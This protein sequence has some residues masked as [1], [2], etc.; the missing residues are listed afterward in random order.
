MWITDLAFSNLLLLFAIMAKAQYVLTSTED[1][2]EKFR[3]L[4]SIKI[5]ILTG[6]FIAVLLGIQRYWFAPFG[7]APFSGASLIMYLIILHEFFG[8]FAA[9]FMKDRFIHVNESAPIVFQV[10]MIA[11]IIFFVYLE[12][13]LFTGG[14]GPLR[15]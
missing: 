6:L 7:V 9:A 2:T 10:L 4:S 3:E 14:T 12:I 5:L 15:T 13:S 11:E 1:L 8:G